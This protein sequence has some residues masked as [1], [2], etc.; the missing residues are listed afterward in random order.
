MPCAAFLTRRIHGKQFDPSAQTINRETCIY[1]FSEETRHYSAKQL[2]CVCVFCRN[3]RLGYNNENRHFS[4]DYFR[5]IS[6]RRRKFPSS[7]FPAQFN[8]FFWRLLVRFQLSLIALALQLL[9]KRSDLPNWRLNWRSTTLIG[10][11]YTLFCELPEFAR[12]S[13]VI[14][15]GMWTQW[16]GKKINS[17]HRLIKLQKFSE[18]K[19]LCAA[20][21][22]VTGG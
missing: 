11:Y 18:L 12:K 5:C 21:R 10:G 14:F 7:F 6:G 2:V 9:H 13:Q 8:R 17:T 15:G 16:K 22:R 4:G 19:I 3:N 1:Q 20:G